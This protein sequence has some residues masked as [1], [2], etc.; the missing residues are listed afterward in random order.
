MTKNPPVILIGR[1]PLLF[2]YTQEPLCFLLSSW[3]GR[4][5]DDDEDE[6][7]SD[8]GND[9]RFGVVA[10]AAAAAAAAAG[11]AGAGA[12][13]AAGEGSVPIVALFLSATMVMGGG[14]RRTIW[15][16]PALLLL[17]LLLLLSSLPLQWL[18]LALL[19]YRS[20]SRRRSGTVSAYAVA[21][22]RRA[23]GIGSLLRLLS[24]LRSATV[25]PS[26]ANVASAS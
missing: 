19:P 6:D 5:D 12:A 10:W 23:C 18:T 14:T 17:L 13:C 8:D 9:G 7:D 26:A 21:S 1:L 3:T 4:D 22:S 20:N 25:F 16:S 24:G 11:C 15:T 2:H